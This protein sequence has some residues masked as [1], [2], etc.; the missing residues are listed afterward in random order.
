MGECCKETRAGCIELWGTSSC[1]ACG[2]TLCCYAVLGQSTEGA[3]AEGPTGN[4]LFK[5]KS[6][7]PVP[8]SISLPEKLPA[9]SASETKMMHVVF[10]FG[11]E[12]WIFPALITFPYIT[13]Y[14][15]IMASVDSFEIDMFFSYYA[16]NVL[17]Q[18]I[19]V[20][21]QYDKLSLFF[22]SSINFV[23][24]ELN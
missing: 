6:I 24:E 19:S 17:M 22:R 21:L 8:L 13:I 5:Y 14:K 3:T 2:T 16:G 12:T 9:F 10:R 20:A 18:N 7:L 1:V 11:I 23:P 15:K 4:V